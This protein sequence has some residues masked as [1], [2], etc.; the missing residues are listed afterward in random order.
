MFTRVSEG[1]FQQ[2]HK[3]GNNIIVQTAQP[4]FGVGVKILNI[5]LD[6]ALTNVGQQVGLLSH[7]FTIRAN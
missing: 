4:N 7:V 6:Y 1:S 3:T 5:S 2:P